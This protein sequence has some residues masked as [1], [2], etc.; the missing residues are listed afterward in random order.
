MYNSSNCPL[1]NT[2][3]YIL[4]TSSLFLIR[5]SNHSCVIVI[6]RYIWVSQEICTQIIF[7]SPPPLL[8]KTSPYHPFQT[9]CTHLQTSSHPFHTLLLLPN[10]PTPSYF[11]CS[12]EVSCQDVSD[13]RDIDDELSRG[14]K[15][16]VDRCF[17]I[18][19]LPYSLY[20]FSEHN[21]KSELT[22]FVY[23]LITKCKKKVAIYK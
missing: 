19:G 11:F 2:Y 1:I 10:L 5:L 8:P 22:T 7:R 6:Y 15:W 3:S 21:N 14:K 12:D 13:K 17:D 23:K 9:S 16:R 20:F 4:L 18:V